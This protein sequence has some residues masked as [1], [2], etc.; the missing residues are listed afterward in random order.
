MLAVFRLLGLPYTGRGSM[1]KVGRA[2]FCFLPS[3]SVRSTA[4][5]LRGIDDG[6][7][8]VIPEGQFNRSQLFWAVQAPAKG[9]GGYTNA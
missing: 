9:T 8:E 2:S 5:S 4:D 7:K 1:P 3:A 6:W